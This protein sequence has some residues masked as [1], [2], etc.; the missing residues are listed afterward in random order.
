[1]NGKFCERNSWE[2]QKV[3]R[4]DNGCF[5]TLEYNSHYGEFISRI[6]DDKGYWHCSDGLEKL[7]ERFCWI[8][9]WAESYNS[10]IPEKK[11]LIPKFNRNY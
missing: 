5:V 11:L 2:K 7:P 8:L 4:L 6:D 3:F 10:N 9:T 1:M